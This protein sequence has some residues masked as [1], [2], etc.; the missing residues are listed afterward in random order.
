MISPRLLRRR[1]RSIQ[2][3]AKITRAMEMI[4]TAKMRRAQEQALAGRP[5]SDK[6]TQVIADLAAEFAGDNAAHPLLEKRKINKIAVV[7]ITSDRGLCGGLN[8]NMNRLTARFILEQSVPVTLITVGRKGRD[9]MYRQQR[10][11]RAEFTK[12]SDRPSMLETLP[13]SHIII[14]DYSTGYIDQV[15]L[16]YTRFVTTMVQNPTLELLLPI[17]PATIPKTETKEFIYEPDPVF[18]L[19]QLLPRFVEMRV[20]HAILEAI[21]SEQSA[22]MVAMRSATDNAND[23]I[24]ELTLILNKARQE[25]ITKELLDITGGVESLH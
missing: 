22:R 9:F 25:M 14:D 20:Y 19:N 4:A 2:S 15:Y 3:T 16:A 8:A 1:I 18:V 23:V 21:A 6:I 7:H 12:I 5:Y 10:D 17:E 13:I 11:V 24:E